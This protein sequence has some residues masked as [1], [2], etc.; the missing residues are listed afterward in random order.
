MIP[1]RTRDTEVAYKS[2]AKNLI[3]TFLR[4]HP[5]AALST[6]P[7]RELFAKWMCETSRERDWSR[8]YWRRCRAAIVSAVRQDMGD[9]EGD[10]MQ[11]TLNTLDEQYRRIHGPHRRWSNRKTKLR[12]LPLADLRLL[13]S[14]LESGQS[15]YGLLAS[16]WLRANVLVGMRPTE[17]RDAIIDE[18]KRTIHVRN[19]KHTNGRGHGE[20][21]TLA[22]DDLP[23]AE[24]SAILDFKRDLDTFSK[25]N[26]WK[27]VY[28]QTRRELGRARVRI[29]T[30]GQK[31]GNISL[32]STRH[33]FVADLRA[34]GKSSV[35]I[36]ALLGHA[37]TD[38][39]REHYG[40]RAR[41]RARPG[42]MAKATA[43]DIDRVRAKA[44]P[45]SSAEIAARAAS[46]AQRAQKDKG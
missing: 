27:K 38:T 39:Q 34:S 5:D 16:R 13:L 35:E 18:A 36:A 15:A 40:L 31:I 10:W 8:S 4:Q 32:Y 17:W 2:A 12:E 14:K 43:D 30:T 33:Q 44:Q 9:E 20:T 25:A 1:T 42:R 22:L 23:D 3:E 29:E 19:A 11:S 24:W 37:D 28:H 46:H 41:G 26:D 7:A 21:R 45:F 6:R